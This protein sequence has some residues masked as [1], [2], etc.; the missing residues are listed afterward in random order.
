MNVPYAY[1]A[2]WSQDPAGFY[3]RATTDGDRTGLAFFSLEDRSLTPVDMPAWDVEDVTVSA[4]GRTVIWS[5]NEDG[6]SVLHGRRDGK[7]MND[8][9]VP[10]GVIRA[11]DISAD[12][13]VLALLLDTP[14]RPL[15]VSVADLS[16]GT[17]LRCLTG[18]NPPALL[19]REPVIPEPCRFPS[20]DG[21]L[22]PGLIYRPPGPGPH[23]VML[24]IHGGPEDQARPL[25]NALQ[26]CLLASGIGLLA[27]NVRGSTGYGRAWQTRIYRDWGG[28]DL[29]D[30]AGAAGWLRSV[31]WVDPGRLAVFGGSYGGSPRCPACR[32]CLRCGRRGCR[33]AGRRTCSRWRGRCRRAGSLW[34]GRCSG[35]LIRMPR[36]CGG[37]HR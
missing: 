8:L 27:P 12:G 32:G 15:G 9:P 2:P 31:D 11:M 16:A 13:A 10:G 4:D 7:R 28:I 20:G 25:Y 21:T 5:V 34:S 1:P 29:E 33:S 17:P 3:V 26:Q 35:I 24:Y 18:S 19:A 30:F 36:S 6:W 22:I 14:A 23:P 37:G